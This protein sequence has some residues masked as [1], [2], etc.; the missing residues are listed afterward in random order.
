MPHTLA[1][2]PFKW[3]RGDPQFL[4]F[5][6]LFFCFCIS[7]IKAHAAYDGTTN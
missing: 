2:I 5:C 3:S 4:N 7:R 6:L 1:I